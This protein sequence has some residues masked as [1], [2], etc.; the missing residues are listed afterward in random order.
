MAGSALTRLL[1]EIRR[2]TACAA[3]LALGPNPVLRVSASARLCIA[4]Q[5]PGLRVHKSGIPFR[6][7]SGDRLRAGMGVNSEVFYDEGLVAIV[8]MGFC[9]PGNDKA[10]GDLPPRPE[11][12]RLW[13]DRLFRAAPKFGLVLAIGSYAQAY[14]LRERRKKSVTE[15]VQA[16][17]EYGPFVIPLPHPSWRNTGW[18]KKHPWFED[19]L[20]PHLRGRV[21]EVLSSGS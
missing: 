21:A 20:I 19:E 14:H 2:C 11:C 13:H 5:A 15:T 9:F 10:G 17:R 8:P 3:E 18:L 4:G 6:D 12:A 7:P 16:W 1:A